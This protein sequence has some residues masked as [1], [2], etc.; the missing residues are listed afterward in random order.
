MSNG[1]SSSSSEERG[2]ILYDEKD[3]QALLFFLD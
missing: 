1:S 3:I 2:Y